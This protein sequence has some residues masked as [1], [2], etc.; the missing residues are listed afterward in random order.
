MANATK[1]HGCKEPIRSDAKFM[2]VKI[3]RWS[4]TEVKTFHYRCGKTAISITSQSVVEER[5]IH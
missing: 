3:K 2:L 1:C 4:G 5:V